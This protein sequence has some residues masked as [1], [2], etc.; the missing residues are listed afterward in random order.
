MWTAATCFSVT[1]PSKSAAVPS[2]RSDTSA[3]GTSAAITTRLGTWPTSSATDA[4][5]ASSNAVYSR[6]STS[7]PGASRSS[8]AVTV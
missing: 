3:S 7:A 1:A 5:D 8:Q 4:I 6:S 2:A